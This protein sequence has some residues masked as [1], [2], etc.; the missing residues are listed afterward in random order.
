MDKK[1]LIIRN[2]VQLLTTDVMVAVVARLRRRYIGM[3]IVVFG[4][5]LGHIFIHQVLLL[6][7]H[8]AQ[9]LV[10]HVMVP[11]MQRVGEI[12]NRVLGSPGTTTMIQKAARNAAT[13]LFIIAQNMSMINYDL[14]F[15][16]IF[17]FL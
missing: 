10:G 6:V 17:L 14:P 15:I 8:F 7:I 4:E 11:I 16:Y 12:A 2:N 1:I 13:H 3:I 5:Q 9:V